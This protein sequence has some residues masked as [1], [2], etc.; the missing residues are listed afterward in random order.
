MCTFGMYF[1]KNPPI[2]QFLISLFRVKVNYLSLS[3]LG[4]LWYVT[5]IQEDPQKRTMAPPPRI[6]KVCTLMPPSPDR[7]HPN[8]GG[9][10]GGRRCANAAA[11]GDD[12][13]EGGCHR[14]Y[15]C[16]SWEAGVTSRHPRPGS[17]MRG[18]GCWGKVMEPRRCQPGAQEIPPPPP[19]PPPLCGGPLAAASARTSSG[20]TCTVPLGLI[21]LVT[22]S[23][24]DLMT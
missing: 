7:A 4:G 17:S 1:C 24:F 11:R 21:S 6:G 19:P 3:P 14:R 12:T 13:A 16:H 18:G 5:S 8:P 9:A 10:I 22:G 23:K 20:R 15:R 2:S